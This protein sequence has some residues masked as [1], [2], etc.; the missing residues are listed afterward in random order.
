MVKVASARISPTP[1][2]MQSSTP[3]ASPPSRK[4][5]HD[6][7]SESKTAIK[8]NRSKKA[9]EDEDDPLDIKNGIKTAI[10]RFDRRLL[11]DYVAQRTKRFEP[12]LSLVEL[13]DRHIP[14]ISDLR[15]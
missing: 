3:R 7:L 9:K 6:E 13:E 10:G 15:S 12:D 5:R 11:A 1:D 2:V 8:K 14:G 4:R